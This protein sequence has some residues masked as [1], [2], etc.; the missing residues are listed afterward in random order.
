MEFPRPVEE[1]ADDEAEKERRAT[2]FPSH[3][4][5]T[6]FLSASLGGALL[7][8]LLLGSIP[9]IGALVGAVF[10]AGVVAFRTR[11]AH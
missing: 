10:G 5:L 1:Y 4:M 8:G 7:G 3:E 11:H 2:M 6:R 9:M